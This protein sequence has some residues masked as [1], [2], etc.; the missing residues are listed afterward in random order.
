MIDAIIEEV[1]LKKSEWQDFTFES[2]YF[3][4]GTPSILTE[5]E[6]RRIIET[7][8]TNFR[9]S[10][11]IELTLEANPDDINP[12]AVKK[13]NSAGINRLSIGLQS[14]NNEELAFMNRSHTAAESLV[15][16][17]T[18][19]Q[20]GIADISV[21]L[22]YGS[23]LKTDK[24][25]EFELNWA[26]N[27]G[28]NHLSAYALTVESKTA[29]AHRI[30]KGLVPETNDE[31]QSNQ[32][33]KLT[34]ISALNEWDFY[35]I[36]NL[37]KP[38]HRSIHNSNYWKNKAYLG[39]GPS[40]HSYK[41]K[42]RFWNASNNAEYIKKI[43]LGELP[44]TSETLSDLDLANEAILTQLRLSSG[45]RMDAILPFYSK[46]HDENKVALKKMEQNQW[47]KIENDTIILL[48]KGRLMADNIS[49]ELFIS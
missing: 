26:L 12:G 39:I 38:G 6:Y 45:L 2:I 41:N 15:A 37:C 10:T 9:F 42:T 49:A 34:E 33:M 14:L 1:L 22:I 46:W 3:G 18:S 23:H 31:H 7:V 24:Q 25:W 40:A 21:D 47:I 35:E 11:H 13:W 4:G 44:Q 43:N 20:S 32:F 17:D 28:A 48:S 30:K 19:L 5:D 27:S 8:K 29:L 36:S 16:V